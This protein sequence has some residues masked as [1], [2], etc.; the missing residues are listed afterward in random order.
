MP[1]NATIGVLTRCKISKIL[2]QAK[3]S[4]HGKFRKVLNLR[5]ENRRCFL[6]VPARGA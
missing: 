3:Y 2:A 5:N 4:V 6:D 1:Y